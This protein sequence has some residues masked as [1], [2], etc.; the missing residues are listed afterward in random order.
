[1]IVPAPDDVHQVLDDAIRRT[2]EKERSLFDDCV[3]ERSIV[4]Q[5][6]RHL[7]GFVE[8]RDG[9]ESRWSVDVEYNRH[10]VYPYRGRYISKRLPG[11]S[12][13]V[14]Y[15]DLIIHDRQASTRDHN[16][17]V[18]EAKHNPSS[19]DRR[20]EHRKLEAFL[21]DY[22]YRHAVFLEFPRRKRPRWVCIADRMSG[23]V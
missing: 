7:A 16:L 15:P 9:W 13:N 11:F 2:Y 3:H 19:A 22:G 23:R 8:A 20:R 1:M 18:L 10:H 12:D 6:G 4:A 5:I 21:G 17:L 14:V